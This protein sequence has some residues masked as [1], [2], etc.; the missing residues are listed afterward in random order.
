MGCDDICFVS[1]PE[2]RR[3]GRYHPQEEYDYQ[4]VPEGHNTS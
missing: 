1:F 4:Q 2:N 3:I